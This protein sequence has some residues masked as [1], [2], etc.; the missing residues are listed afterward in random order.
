MSPQRSSN[1]SDRVALDAFSEPDRNLLAGLAGRTRRVDA[2]DRVCRDGMAE[3]TLHA[4]TEGWVCAVRPMQDGQRQVLDVFLPG[5]WMLLRDLA[6]EE[7]SAT[8]VAATPAVVVEVSKSGL[9][10]RLAGSAEAARHLLDRMAR[11]ESLLIDR[12]A[13]LGRRTAEER[14]VRFLLELHDRLGAPAGRFELPLTQA[15]IADVVGL[16]AVHVS[17]TLGSLR[18]RGLLEIERSTVILHDEASLRA[19]AGLEAGGLAGAPKG[20]EPGVQA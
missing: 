13:S 5:D 8:L 2:G 17:R 9:R 16:S 6:S 14:T 1:G 20:S 12:L 3:P 10:D 7:A 18:D 4:L 11:E 15:L 19:I